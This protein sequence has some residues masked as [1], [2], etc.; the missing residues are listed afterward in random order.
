MVF[1]WLPYVILDFK[2]LSAIIKIHIRKRKKFLVKW[3]AFIMPLGECLL[4][5]HQGLPDKINDQE[6]KILDN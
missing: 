3:W 1:P 6:K 4:A 2:I 5:N